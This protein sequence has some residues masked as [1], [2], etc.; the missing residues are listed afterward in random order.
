MIE[1][2]KEQTGVM[3]AINQIEMSVTSF[4]EDRLVANKALGI[5]IQG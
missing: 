4:R 2:L 5:E 1:F 3:P